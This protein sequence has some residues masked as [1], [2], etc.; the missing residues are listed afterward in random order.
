MP[1]QPPVFNLTVNMWRS[2]AA[3]PDPP[4]LVCDGQL[5]V[6]SRVP[7]DVKPTVLTEYQP[8]IWLR[9]PTG[10]DIIPLDEVEVA[11]GDGWFY[12]VRFTERFH[13]G[14]V[15]EYLGCLLEQFAIV[16]PSTSCVELEDG[17]GHVE[18]ESGGCVLLE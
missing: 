14:F 5:Y 8:A 18:M 12:T 10:T 17:S 9:V 6:N 1:Y 4:S 15:N 2:P 7:V 16:P 11:A 13:R 3:P